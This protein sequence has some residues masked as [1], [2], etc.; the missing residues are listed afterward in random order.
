MIFLL[1]MRLGDIGNLKT[2]ISFAKGKI[3]KTR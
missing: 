2:V 1:P 3:L